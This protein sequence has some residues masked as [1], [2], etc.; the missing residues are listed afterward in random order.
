M[1]LELKDTYVDPT[2]WRDQLLFGMIRIAEVTSGGLSSILKLCRQR[3]RL[4][5][6]RVR[7]PRGSMGDHHAMG[8]TS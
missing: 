2:V 7:L 4:R 8:Q 6:R 1:S 5:V 3:K